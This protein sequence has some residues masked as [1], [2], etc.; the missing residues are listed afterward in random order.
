M[1]LEDAP[2]PLPV[3]RGELLRSGDDVALVA[4]GK[5]VDA[6]L[7]AAD[8]LA[9]AGVSAAVADARFVKPL[10]ACLLGELAE[11][12]GRVVTIEDHGVH[13]GLGS[14][15][16]ELFAECGLRPEV[17]CLGVTDAFVDHGD[18]EDQWREVGID[19][20]SIVAAV[21][22][23]VKGRGGKALPVWPERASRQPQGT[24][25]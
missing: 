12:C 21:R 17:K 8:A 20:P 5:T 15:V 3:G 23:L 10:D 19:A 1:E 14:A 11:S 16:L 9:E 2:R 24:R 18:T 22:D 7:E 6:A 4:L 13:G 25:A